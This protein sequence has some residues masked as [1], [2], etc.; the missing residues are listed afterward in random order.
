MM[1][2][3]QKTGTVRRL[4]DVPRVTLL[5]TMGAL[6]GALVT[7]FAAAASPRNPAVGK[8]SFLARQT[9]V[10]TPDRAFPKPGDTIVVTQENLRGTHGIGADRT[11]CLVVDTAVRLQCTTTVGLPGGTLETA[12]EESLGSKNIIAPILGGTGRYASTRGYFLL[13][14]LTATEYS[15]VLHAS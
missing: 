5:V 3:H 4:R 6:A 14:Q 11:A 9:S 7:G 15:V 8:F 2:G 12:F 1:Q 13:H 10:H